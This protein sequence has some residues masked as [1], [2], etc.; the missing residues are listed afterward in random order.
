MVTL[1]NVTVPQE[2]PLTEAAPEATSFLY[3]LADQMRRESGCDIPFSHFLAQ[4]RLRLAADPDLARK[5]D[6]RRSAARDV[7]SSACFEAW[8]HRE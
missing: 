1:A 8:A 6:A 4:A 5:D 7:E 2:Q 3:R